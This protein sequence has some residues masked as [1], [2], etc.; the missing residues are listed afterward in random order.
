MPSE[1]QTTFNR[2]KK[3][4]TD[5][6][7]YYRMPAIHTSL[8]VVLS[9]FITA[10]FILIALRPTFV[11]ITTLRKTIVDSETTLAKLQTKASALQR[12]SNQRDKYEPYEKYVNSSIPTDG[13][14][15]QNVAAAMEI[16]AAESHVTLRTLNQGEALT[17]SKISDPYSGKHRVVSDM[18]FSLRVSGT[19]TNLSDFFQK[20]LS[21]DRLITIDSLS[22]ARDSQSANDSTANISINISGNIHYLANDS[23]LNGILPSRR[24]AQKTAAAQQETTNVPEK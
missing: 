4:S 16:L 19:Y 12:I 14:R 24:N 9:L 5:L 22:F 1:T 2:Y 11:T 20:L 6:R 18:D 15:Y 3:Y 10:F 23:L 21:L 7:R 8:T 13:P 17:F